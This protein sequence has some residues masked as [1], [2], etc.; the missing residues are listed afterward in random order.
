MMQGWFGAVFAISAGIG[1]LL[2][3][4]FADHISWRW[5]FYINLPIGAVSLFILIVGFK[6]RAIRGSMRE[7]LKRIDYLGAV[8]LL[9]GVVVLLLGI[10]WGGNAYAWDSAMVISLLCGSVVICAA[11]IWVE[12]WHAVEPFIPG[13]MLKSRN[14]ILTMLTS[15]LAGWIIFATVYYYP[16]FYQLVRNK[17]ATQAGLMIIPLMVVCFAGL[18][19]TTTLIGRMGA[20][21]LPT[22]FA[23]GFAIT[24]VSLG[25]SLTFWEE[26]NLAAEIVIM[27]V[28]GLGLGPLW[29]SAYL[30]AQVSAQKKDVSVSTML[31]SFFEMIGATIGLAI[32]GSVFNNAVNSYTGGAVSGSLE[33]VHQL[34]DGERQ[35]IIHGLI[36]AFHIFFI[37]LMAPAA[38]AGIAA[39]MLR[40]GRWTDRAA[41]EKPVPSTAP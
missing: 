29:Q 15:F 10:G 25:L 2:G 40:P 38:V 32:S 36:K 1:P 9:G 23:G 27:C 7:K 12:G 30:A 31:C 21:T 35:V 28:A 20:W 16:L 17:S 24:I 22:F 8:L 39:A 34:P 11:F 26:E 6:P 13:R 19:V 5:A 18:T 37:S 14:I 41:D 3:G 4:I 33:N